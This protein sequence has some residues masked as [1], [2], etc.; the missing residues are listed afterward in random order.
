[1]NNIQKTNDIITIEA[2]IFSSFKNFFIF[3]NCYITPLFCLNF[4]TY[5]KIATRLKVK[6]YFFNKIAF[7]NE[8]YPYLFHC[9]I[10]FSTTIFIV[11]FFSYLFQ[12]V[13]LLFDK[14]CKYI[15]RF[16]VYSWLFFSF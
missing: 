10:S 8:F 14:T 13:Q 5:K 2:I 16:I 6:T 12:L 9:T 15:C 7:K 3:N 1:M 4:P 11:Y